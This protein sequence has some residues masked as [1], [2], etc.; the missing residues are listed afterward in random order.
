[1]AD[2]RLDMLQRQREQMERFIER[3]SEITMTLNG[4]VF[5]DVLMG[6][7]E[8]I[9]FLQSQVEEQALELAK[10][11]AWQMLKDGHVV[12]EIVDKLVEMFGFTPYTASFII[13]EVQRSEE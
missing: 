8:E 1:M 6:I 11:T 3:Q 10:S 12:K 2:N 5:M 13:R 4:G 9:D 7:D